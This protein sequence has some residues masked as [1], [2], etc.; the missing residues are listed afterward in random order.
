MSENENKEIEEVIETE[1]SETTDEVI[2]KRVEPDDLE[3]AILKRDTQKLLQIFEE[4]PDIDIAEA[5]EEIEVSSLIRLF[6]DL[7]S[8]KTAPL[9]DE[10]SQDKKEQL[11]K[12]MTDKELVAL[13]NESYADDIADAV[14]D[15]PAYL[16]T[17][18]LR[19]ADKETRK[20]INRLLKYKEDTA[21][22]IMTTEYLEF[23]E[24]LSVK[25]TI[26]TVRKIGKDAETVY[27]IFVRNA[28]RQFVGTVNLDDLIFAEEDQI[29]DDIMNRDA[30]SVR[31]NT[32]KEEV[33]NTIL[34]Y[35]LNALAVVNDDGCLIGIVTVDDAVDVVVDEANEDIEKMNAVSAL[36]ESYLETKPLKMA[37][38]CVPWII[39]LIILG[40]F[41]SMVLSIFQDKLSTLPIL[42][43]FIP[44]LMDTGGNAGGQTIA[45][46]IRG[47]ALKEFRPKD[48]WKILRKEVV[49]ALIISACVAAFAFLWFTMEQYTGIVHNTGA[50]A[51]VGLDPAAGDWATIWNGQVWSW[52]FFLQVAKVSGVVA[53]TLFITMFV[54][55]MIAVLLPMIVAACKKDPAIVSQPLLTT[56]VDVSS[57]LIYFVVAEAIILSVM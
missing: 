32:D 12:A 23:R 54:A 2:V 14:G 52:D 29:L 11:V 42:A 15:M 16:A 46:M 30:P 1:E 5:C 44:V 21:G 45:L 31:A 39:V 3:Q 8:E 48:I 56:I 38:K 20:D 57:L 7:P 51:A 13:I 6:R 53:G 49:S 34:R 19:A 17:K 24:N 22:A 50:T 4:V 43:A 25:K 10:L 41:S 27:T 55:K 37:K 40:T 33:A 18:V 9:F 28:K 36:D 26:E 35:D 47:L